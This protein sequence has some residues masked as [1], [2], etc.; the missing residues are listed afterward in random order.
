MKKSKFLPILC[1]ALFFVQLIAE[2]LSLV[3]ILYL[4]MLP[5]KYTAILI[6]VYVLGLL[7][8]G[9][10]AFP[11]PKRGRKGA[12]R[13]ILAI[14]LSVL[15]TGLSIF[16]FTVVKQVWDTMQSITDTPQT[17][18]PTRQVFVL[19][20]DPAQTL[21]DAKDYT[22]GI[23]E[24]YD[25]QHTQGAIR[26]IEQQLG[27]QIQTVPFAT[28]YEMVDGLY[29]GTCRA[30][31]LNG[32]YASILEDDQGYKDFSEN[33]R[34][35]CDVTVLPVPDQDPP[36]QEPE[37]ETTEPP[38]EEMTEPA[39]PTE[40]PSVTNTPFI[41]YV[42]G[43]DTRSSKLTVGNSDVNILVVV[44][45]E[46]KQVLLLNTPRDYYIPNPAGD[47]ALDKLTHCGIYGIDCSIEALSDLYDIQVD[48][49]S[50]INFTGFETLVDAVGGVVVSSPVSFTRNGVTINKGE[51]YLTGKEALVFARERYQMP[52]GDNGRGQNQ[53][54]V[55]KAIITKATSGTT[56]IT[57]YAQILDSLQG[58]FITSMEMS[59]ISQLMKMQLSNMAK[60]DIHTYAVTGENGREITYSI[61][62]L[63]ASVMYQD[64]GRIDHGKELIQKVMSG[65]ILTEEDV[66]Y[67]G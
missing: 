40:P 36:A 19:K 17:E 26:A 30:M 41:M 49:Y 34:I 29:S 45:P 56:I 44:N 48:Y 62:G 43:S 39:A 2:G 65:Q 63:Y 42:S 46:T 59:E 18:G 27:Q 58:M 32:G 28:V 31:I 25:V 50:Q 47:G 38:T 12:F 4:D 24:N 57:N 55:V 13:R 9:L 52:G 37:Q 60:W 16:A 54:K 22:F 14:F 20:D 6:A 15:I 11:R 7:L 23:V 3:M 8:T 67:S 61:P 64:Q 35:L 5:E 66:K 1:I 51:N 53:M 21:A 10:L 33:T